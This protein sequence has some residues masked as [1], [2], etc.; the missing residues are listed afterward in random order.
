MLQTGA[1][2]VQTFALQ[3]NHRAPV[4]RLAFESERAQRDASCHTRWG[5]GRGR[6]PRGH[7]KADLARKAQPPQLATG[8]EVLGLVRQLH[9]EV[10][11]G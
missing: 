7:D 6:C 11:V 5:S 1:V 8:R 9:R 3:P 10:G 4:L 2:D